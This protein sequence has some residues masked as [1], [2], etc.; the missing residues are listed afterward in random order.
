MNTLQ[1]KA[2]RHLS[3]GKPLKSIF[4]LVDH[5]AMAWDRLLFPGSFKSK[6][7]LKIKPRERLDKQL[8]N[9][10][11]CFRNINISDSSLVLSNLNL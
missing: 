10:F 8:D 3:A 2:Q 9:V 5:Q 7:A 11:L 6:H 4:F 1:R